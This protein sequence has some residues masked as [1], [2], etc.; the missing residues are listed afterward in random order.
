MRLALVALL[1]CVAS[2][3]AG[4]AELTLFDV[5]LKTATRGAIRSG[6]EAAGGVLR[7][8]KGSTD[9]FDATR[10]P[11]PGARSLEVVYLNGV[12]VM[13]QYALRADMKAEERLRKMLVEKYGQPTAES[14]FASR[15]QFDGE[16]VM[17]GKYRWL[18]DGG[19]SLIFKKE[20]GFD[21]PTYL[22]YLNTEQ[23][24]K[25]EAIVKDADRRSVK[26]EAEAKGKVF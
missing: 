15:N 12:L 23:E 26:K 17:D 22:T 6:I 7:S 18:F 14:S 1:L 4:A 3:L 16:Y 5:T 13:A 21:S 8:S 11:L 2:S 25:L 19:M 24:A 10:I 9:I 20:F